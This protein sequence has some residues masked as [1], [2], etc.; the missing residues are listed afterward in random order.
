MSLRLSAEVYAVTGVE[1]DQMDAVSNYGVNERVHFCQRTMTASR[2]YPVMKKI[3]RRAIAAS[4]ETAERNNIRIADFDPAN[5]E[6]IQIS[7]P[8]Y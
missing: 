2:G 6:V 3:V 4:R 1:D 8:S 5:D 7:G